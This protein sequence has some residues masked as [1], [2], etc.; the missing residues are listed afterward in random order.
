MTGFNNGFEKEPTG[1]PV[2]E[3][4]TGDGKEVAPVELPENEQKRQYLMSEHKRWRDETYKEKSALSPSEMASSYMIF[5][6]T[7][8]NIANLDTDEGKKGL[9][10][11]LAVTQAMSGLQ[12]KF[13]MAKENNQLAEYNSSDTNDFSS[14][15]SK[16]SQISANLVSEM[17]QGKNESKPEETMDEKVAREQQ[18][19]EEIANIEKKFHKAGSENREGMI[20]GEIDEFLDKVEMTEIQK[21][22]ITEDLLH[23]VS[24]EIFN[25]LKQTNRIENVEMDGKTYS[26]SE[27]NPDN[28]EDLVLIWKITEK[29]MEDKDMSSEIRTATSRVLSNW[30]AN[31][32][33]V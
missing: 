9:I 5:A 33:K 8:L 11:G 21:K 18:K 7:G 28:K 1:N 32:E 30:L 15:L 27:L 22:E 19:E 25:D 26:L 16:G 10:E 24:L 20:R 3:F 14:Y 6:T 17:R 2:N 31:F 4:I 29:T 23:I 12:G 13:A